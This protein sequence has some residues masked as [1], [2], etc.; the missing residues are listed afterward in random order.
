VISLSSEGN[1][2]RKTPG[3][4]PRAVIKYRFIAI[5]FFRQWTENPAGL[6]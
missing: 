1:L 3:A 6:I 2:A 4:D 5:Q